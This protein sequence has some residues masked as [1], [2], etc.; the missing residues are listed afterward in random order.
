MT[1]F[2]ET[3]WSSVKKI[4]APYLFD[5]EH[6][7]A[8]PKMQGNRASSRSEGG[9]SWFFSS[10]GGSLVYNLE[11]RRG[12]PSKL[13]FVQERLNSCLVTRD[14]SGISLRLGRAIRMLLE[15][16]QEIRVPF[17]LPL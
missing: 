10:C 14:S 3:L 12:G 16:R 17:Q 6:G 11:L 4:K 8:L 1:V 7:I 9:V 13:E 15:V 2:L 5:G